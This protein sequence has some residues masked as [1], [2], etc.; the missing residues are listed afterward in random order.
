MSWKEIRN[1]A[2]WI[3]Q[4]QERGVADEVILTHVLAALLQWLEDYKRLAYT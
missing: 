2:D 1:I 3:K 4:E